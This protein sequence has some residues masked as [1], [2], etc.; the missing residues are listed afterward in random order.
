MDQYPVVC[1][2]GRKQ[3]VPAGA[4]G[5]RLPCPCGR[6]VAV[7]ALHILRR[8]AGEMAVSPELMIEALLRENGLPEGPDC[9]VCSAATDEVRYVW[10]DCEKPTIKKPGWTIN[11]LMLLFGWWVFY[12]SG[13]TR[14]LGRDITYRLPLRVCR[15]C[16]DGLRGSGVKDIL[17]RVP[18]YERLLQKYPKAKLTLEPMK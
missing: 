12:R 8:D 18:L 11:P 15:V 10:A 7:P 1:E 2:C 14:V 5:R 6:E 9:V 16:A 13:E 3:W 4:A 17:C